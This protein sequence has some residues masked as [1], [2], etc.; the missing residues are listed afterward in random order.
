MTRALLI[1]LT[2]ALALA[3]GAHATTLELVRG[4]SVT[5]EGRTNVHPWRCES[6]AIGGSLQTDAPWSMLEIAL[7]SASN[8]TA[9]SVLR[10]LPP[11]ISLPV[12]SFSAAIPVRSFDCGNRLMENDLRKALKAEQAPEIRF[13][14]MDLVRVTRGAS[15]NG[16]L[17]S[18]YL[19]LEVEL[20]LA[21]ATRRI[22][23]VL[24]VERTSRTSFRLE[25]NTQLRMTDFGITPPTGMLGMIRAADELEVTVSLLL[26]SD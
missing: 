22:P 14:Y 23:M 7:A 5:L 2:C 9:G 15:G 13:R 19:D 8:A 4:S 6:D 11:D 24:R 25:G 18:W 21:G 16:A 17:A 26:Q 3:A 1:A 20:R 12:P 10:E